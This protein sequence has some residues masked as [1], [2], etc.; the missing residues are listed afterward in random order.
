MLLRDR[1]TQPAGRFSLLSLLQKESCHI[2]ML[3]AGL[4]DTAAISVDIPL[5]LEPLAGV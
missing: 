2:S 5:Q 3:E 4:S 1:N